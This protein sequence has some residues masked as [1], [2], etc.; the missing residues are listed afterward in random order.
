MYK[1][2]ADYNRLTLYK[3]LVTKTTRIYIQGNRERLEKGVDEDCQRKDKDKE[4]K[5]G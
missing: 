2:P 1:W 4:G 5:A 3:K